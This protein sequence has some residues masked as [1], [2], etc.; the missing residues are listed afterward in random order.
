MVSA[1]TAR[2][3]NGRGDSPSQNSRNSNTS[4]SPQQYKRTASGEVKT[5]FGTMTG[6]TAIN[7]N[8]NN[9][10]KVE[11]SVSG[12]SADKEGPSSVLPPP[13]LSIDLHG[14]E[15][16]NKNNSC[17][18]TGSTA[19]SRNARDCPKR[20][21]TNEMSFAASSVKRDLERAKMPYK[22][23]KKDIE[24]VNR[25]DDNIRIK[26]K[27]VRLM[28]SCDIESPLIS[29]NIST[30][31]TVA[32]YEALMHAVSDSYPSSTGLKSFE[33]S[34]TPQQD[35]SSD[36]T[37][38]VSDTESDSGSDNV[39]NGSNHIL[40]LPPLVE[41]ALDHTKAKKA[42]VPEPISQCNVISCA[43]NATTMTESLQLSSEA[44]CVKKNP[45]VAP[46]RT[47]DGKNKLPI[48]SFIFIMSPSS[49]LY[50]YSLH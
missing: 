50:S 11:S 39:N 13:V 36:S 29:S 21:K 28:H 33:P 7:S 45:H 18:M 31:S 14:R 32:D 20:R 25:S 40:F 3:L 41:D 23:M 49:S 10:N 2:L 42:K 16:K 8:N 30:R 43:S 4:T 22:K 17:S 34:Q 19:S 26:L 47:I 9:N 15:N 35:G 38:S 6:T 5:A 46:M 12:Y 27:G 37:S 24:E 1:L 44:R 48:S